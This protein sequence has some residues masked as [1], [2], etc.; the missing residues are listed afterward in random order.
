MKICKMHKKF[1]GLTGKQN[2][3]VEICRCL[4]ISP[5]HLMNKIC[6]S[7]VCHGKLET[8][9]FARGGVIDLLGPWEKT[10]ATQ[11]VDWRMWG[12]LFIISRVQMGSPLAQRLLSL[13]KR[14]EQPFLSTC[15]SALFTGVHL[16]K[17]K[18]SAPVVL[19]ATFI[20]DLMSGLFVLVFNL[21]W[22]E[23]KGVV[24]PVWAGTGTQ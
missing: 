11:Q 1:T 5:K 7:M 20:C 9:V 13:S 16:G 2:K 15:V 3:W 10:E 6:K 12:A 8:T 19:Q 18:L 17:A 24:L 23:S 14:H 4:Q 21:W 22:W